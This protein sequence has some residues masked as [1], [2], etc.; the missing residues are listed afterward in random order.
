M[1]FDFSHINP[2]HKFTFNW[3]YIVFMDLLFCNAH[4]CTFFLVVRLLHLSV[5][6]TPYVYRTEHLLD[7]IGVDLAKNMSRYF[8]EELRKT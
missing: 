5:F 4:L 7:A 1:D 3:T 8:V 2:V 6:S